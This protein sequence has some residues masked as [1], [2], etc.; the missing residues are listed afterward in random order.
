MYDRHHTNVWTLRAGSPRPLS[1]LVTKGSDLQC[2]KYAALPFA[3]ENL[4]ASSGPFARR[5]G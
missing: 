5:A 1:D 2:R 4:V 3:A